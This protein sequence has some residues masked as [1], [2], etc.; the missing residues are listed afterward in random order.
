MKHTT[1]VKCFK[2]LIFLLNISGSL[3]TKFAAVAHLAEG[4]F[5]CARETWVKFLIL[6][7]GTLRL[8]LSVMEG[9]ELYQ[10]DAF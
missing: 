9:Q 8:M 6:Q 7:D 3:H 10:G 4:Q 1:G 5:L 2:Y